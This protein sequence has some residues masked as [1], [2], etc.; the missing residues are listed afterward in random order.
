MSLLEMQPDLGIN[1]EVLI[2]TK[3]FC[4]GID[5]ERLSTALAN[6]YSAHLEQ[7]HSLIN[8]TLAQLDSNGNLNCENENLAFFLECLK[9]M[10]TLEK[11]FGSVSSGNGN[12]VDR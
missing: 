6:S 5:Q 8:I 11:A 4:D 9:K 10:E 12:T 2:A 3:R 7:L 1:M